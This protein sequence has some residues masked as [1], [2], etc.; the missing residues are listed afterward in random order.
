MNKYQNPNINFWKD[1][2]VLLT[3]H[4]GFKG[5]WLL[6]WLMELGAEVWGYSLEPKNNQ[7]MFEQIKSNLD[8]RKFHNFF[9]NI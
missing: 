6:I 3:G 4:T 1:K 5:I 2:K 8:I 9:G 7:E